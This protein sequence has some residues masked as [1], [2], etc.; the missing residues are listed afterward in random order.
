MAT[1][2]VC[3]RHTLH[4]YHPDQIDYRHA[5]VHRLD[6]HHWLVLETN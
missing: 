2:A 5:R 4:H 6:R 3:D 1:R